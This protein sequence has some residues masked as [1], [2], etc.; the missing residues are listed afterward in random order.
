M[1]DP[2]ARAV[3]AARWRSLLTITDGLYAASAPAAVSACSRPLSDKG[4]SSW[5]CQIPLA[6]WAVWPCRHTISV[7]PP[8]LNAMSGGEVNGGAVLP[9]P[10]E[11]VVGPLFLVLDVY[12]DVRE[13]DQD[14]SAVALTFTAY[15]LDAELS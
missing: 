1:R 9:E 3:S 2:S 4:V 6:L 15:R 10:L 12:D 7:R 14:P 13:V 11:L 5:P 8:S